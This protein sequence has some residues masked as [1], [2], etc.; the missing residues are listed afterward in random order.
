MNE[1]ERLQLFSLLPKW[2]DVW[3]GEFFPL[4]APTDQAATHILLLH[5]LFQLVRGQLR[6]LQRHG[7]QTYKPVRMTR[8][9][10]CDFLIL[11]LDNLTCQVAL[12]PI[13]KWIDAYD[14]YVNSFSVHPL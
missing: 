10:F 5:A 2:I 11:D 4:D 13:P 1:D 14:L 6:E 3:G 12:C 9:Q 7:S 8:A